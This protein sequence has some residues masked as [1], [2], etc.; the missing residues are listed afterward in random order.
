M[1]QKQCSSLQSHSKEL[2][3]TYDGHCCRWFEGQHLQVVLS[4]SML[5]LHPL[6]LSQGAVSKHGGLKNLLDALPH[7]FLKAC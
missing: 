4:S 5:H 6:P 2:A 1:S 3:Y 7:C